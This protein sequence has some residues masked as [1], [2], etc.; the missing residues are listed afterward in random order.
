MI[1]QKVIPFTDDWPDNSAAYV[2][3]LRRRVNSG[4]PVDVRLRVKM[5]SSIGRSTS[6][7]TSSASASEAS[8]SELLPVLSISV[9]CV[10]MDMNQSTQY[11]QPFYR[12]MKL[13]CL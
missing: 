9:E 1:K 12:E 10:G 6:T 5:F 11:I 4:D 3:V 13:A 2:L 8:P 7:A